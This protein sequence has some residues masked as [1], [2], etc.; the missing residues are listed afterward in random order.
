MVRDQGENP[1]P[2]EPLPQALL[3][4]HGI[5]NS[6]WPSAAKLVSTAGKA[7]PH[8]GQPHGT[9]TDFSQ[10]CVHQL[11]EIQ[12][13]R[14]PD[15]VA[16][17]DEKRQLTYRQ[18][19]ERANQ[20]GRFLQRRGVGPDVLVGVAVAD[21]VTLP[22]SVAFAT[23]AVTETAGAVAVTGLSKVTAQFDRSLP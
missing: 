15:S 10:V 5:P 14:I 7:R 12:A 8:L 16:V 3:G 11:F 1:D 21:T 9:Q 23:G 4:E 18:L 13:A 17:A 6:E 22:D 2:V 19:N 20:L